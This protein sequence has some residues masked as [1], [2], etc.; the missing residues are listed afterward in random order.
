MAVEMRFRDG[1][2]LPIDV[3]GFGASM[4]VGQSLA[5][6][7]RWPV[8]QGNQPTSLAEF[9]DLSGT[10]PSE[11]DTAELIVSGNL[12]NVH[13][14]GAGMAGGRLRI[15]GSAGRHVG[16]QMSAGRIDVTG[17]CSDFLGAELRGGTIR[18]AGDAGNLVGGAYV[19]SVRGMTGGVI[20]V[21]GSAGD[22]IG[23]SLRRG[24]IAVGGRAGNFAGINLIAGTVWLRGGC[25][26]HPGAGMRRGTLVIERTDTVLLPTFRPTGRARPTF[27]NLYRRRLC[28]LGLLPGPE[29]SQRDV[30]QFSGDHLNGGRGEVFLVD[31]SF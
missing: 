27:L 12:A 16:A 9:F 26:A 1:G 17:D 3:G 19:G 11:L 30:A 5:E 21:A 7:E 14:L 8:W 6:L 13:R 25:G 22:E 31:P 18:V 23:H 4:L 20:V 29:A 24:L 15:E 2:S 28:E 10:P